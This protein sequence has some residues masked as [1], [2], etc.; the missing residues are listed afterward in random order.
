MLCRDGIIDVGNLN[1]D[2]R[3]AA[4]CEP[5]EE[6]VG[7][8]AIALDSRIGEAALLA[9]PSREG[10]NLCMMRMVLASGFVE[11]TQEAQPLN[12]ATDKARSR[13]G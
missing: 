13:L 6:V 5:D 1:G 9:Q 10:C 2:Q 11:P 3:S 12:P 8:T 7:G 4:P